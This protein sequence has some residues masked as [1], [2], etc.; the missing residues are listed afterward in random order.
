MSFF[1]VLKVL[2]YIPLRIVFPTKIIGKEKYF[3]E[4]AVVCVTH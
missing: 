1:N 4:K 2:S 3:K